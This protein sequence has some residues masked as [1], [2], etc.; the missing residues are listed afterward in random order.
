M[1]VCPS[2]IQ[3]NS[4][5]GALFCPYCGFALP[6][7]RPAVEG[8]PALGAETAQ[9]TSEP[10]PAQPR[11]RPA[12]AAQENP[13]A[14]AVGLGALAAAVLLAVVMSY[15]FGS[16]GPGH[17]ARLAA[18]PSHPANAA[19]SASRPLAAPHRRS[20]PEAVVAPPPFAH[21]TSYRGSGYSFAYPS[22]WQV[23]RSDQPITTY[24]QTVLQSSDGAAKVNVD[25]SPGETTDP[26]SKA[27]QVEAATRSTT[28]GYRRIAFRS[29]AVDGHA[30]FAWEFV[31]ADTEPRRADLFVRVP[32]GEF[33]LL[34]HG[35]DLAGA[36]AAARSIAGSVSATN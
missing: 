28:P 29:T 26:A 6:A 4:D 19:S 31:V 22:G 32:G 17:Q 33:A 36:R 9:F 7:G 16:S 23:S 25:Y 10:N 15:G 5:P 21:L 20:R 12:W 3:P 24:R 27:S 18:V 14:V 35:V 8:F 30:A 13:R 1:S 34:A 2:C 11:Q